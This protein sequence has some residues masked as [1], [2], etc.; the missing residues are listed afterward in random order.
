MSFSFIAWLFISLCGS[1][2]ADRPGELSAVLSE[3][4]QRAHGKHCEDIL[5]TIETKMG[6]ERK[7]W[8]EAQ[9]A[10]FEAALRPLFAILPHGNTGRLG[11]E[12]ARYAL[13]RVFVDARGWKCEWP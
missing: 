2:H 13:H 12:M 7:E 4:S 11:P 6:V 8:I 10:S 1:G 5:Q 3:I 9:S